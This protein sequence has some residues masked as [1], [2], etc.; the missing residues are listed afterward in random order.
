[1]T[2]ARLLAIIVLFLC[3]QKLKSEKMY[4]LVFDL[5]LPLKFDN[6]IAGHNGAFQER[7]NERM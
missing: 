4:L 5:G 2:G 7:R 3:K 6:S 1:M